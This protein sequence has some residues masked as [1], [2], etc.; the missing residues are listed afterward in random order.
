M[1]QKVQLD[2][3]LR[4][5]TQEMP[6]T[7]S[8]AI[9]LFFGIGS[10]HEDDSIAGMSHVIEHMVF[11]GTPRRPTSKEVAEAIEEVGGVMNAGTEK[12]TTNYWAKVT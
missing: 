12:E 6:H 4:I 5:L 8:V 2:N 11:K 1:Y 10:R 9:S 7:Y 3:G